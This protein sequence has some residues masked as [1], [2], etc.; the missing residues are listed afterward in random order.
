[1]KDDEI[2][3]FYKEDVLVPSLSMIIKKNFLKTV[4]IN[5]GAVPFIAKGADLMRPGIVE[6]CE[7][8]VEGSIV[9]I[10]DEKNKKPIAIGQSLFTTDEIDDLDTGKVIL[11]LHHVNDE[12][13]KFT[14]NKE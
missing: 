8:I 13:W 4:T 7:D 9:A 12:I 6:M 2:I 3:F 14:T 5:M 10:I 11:N 1:M